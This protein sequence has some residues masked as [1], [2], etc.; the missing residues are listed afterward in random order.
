[1]NLINA[2]VLI[3]AQYAAPYEGNFIASLRRLQSKLVTDFNATC[4]FVFPKAMASQAWA[5]RFMEE[6]TVFLSGSDRRLICKKEADSILKQFNPDLIYTHFEGY[7]TVM[8]YAASRS[9]NEPHV[10]WH[11]HDTLGYHPNPIKG[12]YQRFCFFKHYGLPFVIQF[13]LGGIKPCIIGVCAHE[14]DFV[15]HFRLGVTTSETVLPNG[16]NIL[17][18][19]SSQRRSHDPITFLAFAGR[20]V[21]KRVDLLLMAADNLNKRGKRIR[22]VLVDGHQPSVADTV[23][24]Y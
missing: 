5:K 24:G 14:P 9:K 12:L 23:F 11:M 21:Q 17:R 19:D 16:I 10:V 4:A 6:N 8:T 1:M 2:R 3:A 20:N 22:V 15:R 18:I 7:D 13:V